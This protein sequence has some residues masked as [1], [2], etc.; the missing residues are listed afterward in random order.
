MSILRQSEID[1][2]SDALKRETL[3]RATLSR[4]RLPETEIAGWFINASDGPQFW[5]GTPPQYGMQPLYLS[6][7]YESQQPVAWRA[8]SG[9]GWFIASDLAMYRKDMEWQPLYTAR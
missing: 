6:P 3:K 4:P 2:M 8:T 5:Y 1:Q 7:A 9:E